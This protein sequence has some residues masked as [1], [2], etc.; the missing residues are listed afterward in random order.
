MLDML[1]LG[2]NWI[3]AAMFA[4]AM[5][6]AIP[7]TLSFMRN[8]RAKDEVSRRLERR[9]QGFDQPKKRASVVRG[10]STKCSASSTSQKAS[11]RASS[12]AA[13]AK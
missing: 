1:N 12:R 3:P 10:R 8:V 6:L 11:R 4:A 7:G 5:L 9:G 2:Q 13:A